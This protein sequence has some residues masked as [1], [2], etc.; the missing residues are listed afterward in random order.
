MAAPGPIRSAP[1]GLVAL[2]WTIRFTINGYLKIALLAP[3]STVP[4]HIW[5]MLPEYG[6][7]DTKVIPVED[8]TEDPGFRRFLGDSRNP[9]FHGEAFFWGVDCHSVGRCEYNGHPFCLLAFTFAACIDYRGTVYGQQAAHAARLWLG[10]TPR[11][12]AELLRC[13]PERVDGLVFREARPVLP[14]FYHENTVLAPSPTVFF[15]FRE[16][17]ENV[18]CEVSMAALER[19]A[20]HVRAPGAPKRPRRCASA[21][22]A[23]R[24]AAAAAAAAV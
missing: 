9:V 10:L 4:Q 22:A 13:D 17:D 21:C 7:M 18:S 23:A 16:G 3:K 1:G 24:A 20:G 12:K 8:L 11:E 5:R 15:A 6:S 2:P 14:P 19:L